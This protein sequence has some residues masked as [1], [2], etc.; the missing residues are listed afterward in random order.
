MTTTVAEQTSKGPA[1]TPTA[2]PPR[3]PSVG[4]V[5]LG[6]LVLFN[7]LALWGILRA[8]DQKSWVG[9]AVIGVCTAL[10]DVVYATRRFIPGKYL[11]PGTI[12]L[13]FFAIFPVI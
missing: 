6:L 1:A 7:G 8:I 12:F 5:G 3:P 13:A 4:V 2:G 9:V 11:L 10:V